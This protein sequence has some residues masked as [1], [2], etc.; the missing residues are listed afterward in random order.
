MPPWTL[1]VGFRD[2]HSCATR[3]TVISIY[4][5]VYRAFLTIL[6]RFYFPPLTPLSFLRCFTTHHYPLLSSP[7]RPLLLLFPS[8]QQTLYPNQCQSPPSSPPSPSPRSCLL[9]LQLLVSTYHSRL[10]SFFFSAILVL[11][12]IYSFSSQYAILSISN[13]LGRNPPGPS[14]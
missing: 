11:L 5:S 6:H 4:R 10:P 9:S 2:G 3:S 8:L 13:G 14:L 7:L 1:R 12:I